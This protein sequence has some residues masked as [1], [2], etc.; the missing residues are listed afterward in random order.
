MGRHDV[1]VFGDRHVQSVLKGLVQLAQIENT[2]DSFVVS[3]HVF[4]WAA[5]ACYMSHYITDHVTNNDWEEAWR[6]LSVAAT[7]SLWMKIHGSKYA[8]TLPVQP[9]IALPKPIRISDAVGEYESYQSKGSVYKKPKT[10]Y[11]LLSEHS[12]PNA[13]CLMLYQHYEPNGTV[14]FTDPEPTSPLPFVNWCLIDLL[15]FL[16]NL[17]DLAKELTVRPAVI[18]L[19]MELAKRAPANRN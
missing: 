16:G 14:R 4:E 10:N 12:H 19:L 3:R 17:L 2:A 7:G 13:A 9:P 8:G 1:R 15:T 6:L 18:S 11:S 5:H